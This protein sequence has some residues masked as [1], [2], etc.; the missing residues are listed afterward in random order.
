VAPE[1]LGV[2]PE[3][4]TVPWRA[5]RL[6]DG[7]VKLVFGG[8][9]TV[10]VS[11]DA[12]EIASDVPDGSEVSTQAA[13]A[14][15][16]NEGEFTTV[17]ESSGFLRSAYQ[18]DCTGV[19]SHRVDWQFLRSSWRGFLGYSEKNIGGWVSSVTNA[20]TVY[21]A[22]PRGTSGSYNYKLRSWSVVNVGGQV[23]TSPPFD[24]R[25]SN[26]HPCGTGIS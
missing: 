22:C 24:S 6:A 17:R 23:S 20:Q 26:Q 3:G 8:I 4:A 10:P 13:W 12:V 5:E 18:V 19:S 7:R 15:N 21:A 16:V 14:C 2:E 11:D 1:S 9:D 25:Q